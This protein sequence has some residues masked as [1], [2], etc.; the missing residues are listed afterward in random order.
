MWLKRVK[1]HRK[2]AKQIRGIDEILE[3]RKLIQAKY[4]EMGRKE[5]HS[6]EMFY[7]GALELISWLL[8]EKDATPQSR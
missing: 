5:E 3:K 7:K 4:L 1:F 2:L 8:K 6:E